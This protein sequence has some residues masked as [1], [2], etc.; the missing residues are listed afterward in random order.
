MTTQRNKVHLIGFA[1]SDPEVRE[2]GN[3][4][5]V[6]R[7]SIAVHEGYRNSQG[8]YVPQTQWH[9]LVLWNK[10][11]EIAEQLVHK[12]TAFA[13]E[14]R[15]NSN[16]YTA[17]DGTKRYVTEVVVSELQLVER[18]AEKEPEEVQ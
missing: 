9:K 13:I 17:K 11:A 12:G 2:V 1:G 4:Q 3:N 16:S 10:Q 14:G 18:E 15:L 8:E 7:V 5:K 6:A